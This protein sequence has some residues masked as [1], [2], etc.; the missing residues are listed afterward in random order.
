MFYDNIFKINPSNRTD[1]IPNDICTL[2]SNASKIYEERRELSCDNDF[3][4][5]EKKRRTDNFQA[6]TNIIYDALHKI[7]D[8]EVLIQ[9][10][11]FLENKSQYW[12]ADFVLNV[13]C[14]NMAD[15]KIW[16]VIAKGISNNESTEEVA[17]KLLPFKMP[18]YGNGRYLVENY[19][20]Y[21]G[22]R[23]DSD[24]RIVERPTYTQLTFD[25]F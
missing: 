15:Q 19:D 9:L 21:L 25:F 7:D 8:M 12:C 4:E 17:M 5:I 24:D 20:R 13:F 1:K 14:Y 3:S 22:T 23:T 18:Y 16:D 2:F 6:I 11:N 10:Y